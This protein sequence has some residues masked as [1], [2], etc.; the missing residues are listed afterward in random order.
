MLAERITRATALVHVVAGA[1]ERR[2]NLKFS[3]NFSTIKSATGGGFG[4]IPPIPSLPRVE[5]GNG[6]LVLDEFGKVLH[7]DG[8]NVELGKCRTR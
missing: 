1:S 2:S 5:V 6:Q 4:G 3:G 7:F 8:N